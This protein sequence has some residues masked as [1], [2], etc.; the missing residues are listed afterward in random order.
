MKTPVCGKLTSGGEGPTVSK[1]TCWVEEGA[2]EETAREL[3][4]CWKVHLS[5]DL[6]GRRNNQN[7]LRELEVRER[8]GRG[9][10][11]RASPQGSGQSRDAPRPLLIGALWCLQGKRP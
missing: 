2:E 1:R 10:G 8:R 9:G 5:G 7:E 4:G 3:R 11:G 6:K